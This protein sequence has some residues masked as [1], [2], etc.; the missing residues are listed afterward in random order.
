MLFRSFVNVAR[1]AVS[2]VRIRVDVSHPVV[3][4]LQAI[5]KYDSVVPVAEG[6]S[7]KHSENEGSEVRANDERL[8]HDSPMS[9]PASSVRGNKIGSKVSD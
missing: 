1:E 2:G 4:G 9:S 7:W 6:R 8:T 3:A 5:T